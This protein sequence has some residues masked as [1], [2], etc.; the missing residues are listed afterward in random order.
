MSSPLIVFLSA[1]IHDSR[2]ENMFQ[3]NIP[4][5]LEDQ[6][7]VQRLLEDD[8]SLQL[9]LLQEEETFNLFPDDEEEE[10][11]PATAMMDDGTMPTTHESSS[12]AFDHTP[13][14]Q[15]MMVM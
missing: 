1:A 6:L 14:W 9:M 11:Y 3:N 5:T 10:E 15:Y 7:M 13:L 2:V 12:G 8:L 4:P